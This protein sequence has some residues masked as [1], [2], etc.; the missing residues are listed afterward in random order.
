MEILDR[1]IDEEGRLHSTRLLTMKGSLP[2][3]I[4]IFVPVRQMHMLETVVVDPTTQQMWVS[5]CNLNCTSVMHALSESTYTPAPSQPG[6]T[7]YQI[8]IFV[9]AFPNRRSADS[10]HR[11]SMSASEVAAQVITAPAAPTGSSSA[12]QQSPMPSFP[13]PLRRAPG[14]R[15]RAASHPGGVVNP[16]PKFNPET[17][18]PEIPSPKHSA[19]TPKS[20]TPQP[21]AASWKPQLGEAAVNLKPQTPNPKP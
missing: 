8:S 12:A 11:G 7:R 15:R 4:Q 9:K 13:A 2:A 18:N 16:K 6:Q 20:R 19:Q 1:H 10:N 5:T 14:L 3:F 17:T 21:Q